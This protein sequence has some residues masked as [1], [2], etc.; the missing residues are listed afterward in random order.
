[1]LNNTN[2]I[3][4]AQHPRHRLLQILIFGSN[5]HLSLVKYDSCNPNTG[6][7][8]G[9]TGRKLQWA[10]LARPTSTYATRQPKHATNRT[11]RRAGFLVRLAAPLRKLAGTLR[12]AGFLVLGS[13]HGGARHL[14]LERDAAR[15]KR[16]RAV[17]RAVP[18][19]KAALGSNAPRWVQAS[20]L[21]IALFMPC[22]FA[23]CRKGI[24][25][26]RSDFA[27]HASRLPLGPGSSPQRRCNLSA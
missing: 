13:R 2:F 14:V 22:R 12:R 4:Q 16:D 20:R 6:F 21:P 8:P 5:P 1:M 3:D 23:A 11:L 24:S 15:E 18:P 26:A 25:L 27:D 7:W 17:F 9:R 19:P 10:A